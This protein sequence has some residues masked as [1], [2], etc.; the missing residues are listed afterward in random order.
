MLA[1]INS[2]GKV[3]EDE[4]EKKKV[5]ME[6]YQTLLKTKEAE[7]LVYELEFTVHLVGLAVTSSLH[8][9]LTNSREGGKASG[10]VANI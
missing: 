6:F 2:T 7:L 8:L 3:T 9:S 4:D 5:H 1:M 10:V